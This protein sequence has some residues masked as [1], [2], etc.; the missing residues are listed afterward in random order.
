MCRTGSSFVACLTLACF[1]PHYL[2]KRHGFRKNIFEPKLCVLMFST[3]FV[4]K[5]VLLWSIQQHIMTNLLMSS[6]KHTLL[7]DRSQS[8][9][10]A[11][12]F[13]KIQRFQISRN[14]VQWE[15]N[16]SVWTDGQADR[17]GE[18]NGRLSQF[19]ERTW[20]FKGATNLKTSR[21]MGLS[22]DAWVLSDIP[23]KPYAP[24]P[25][26][27]LT[28]WQY[29]TNNKIHDAP[30]YVILSLAAVTL[31][32]LGQNTFLSALSWNILSQCSL[33]PIKFRRVLLTL[34]PR[35]IF[36]LC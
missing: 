4:W 27:L 2:K 18:A 23:C 11:T 26:I 20:K 19:C 7:S 12:D 8:W 33:W 17:H 24:H 28:I 6:L 13:R 32:L 3:T 5:I 35:Q 36:I 21:E 29:L 9:I 25:P 31:P 15:P 14:S 1:F 22:A 16:C 34:H 10:F 30:H